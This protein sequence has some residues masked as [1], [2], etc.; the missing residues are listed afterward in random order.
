MALSTEQRRLLGIALGDDVAAAAI[1]DVIDAG[2]NPVAAAIAAIG[3]TSNISAAALSTSDTY[4]DAA[5][6]AELDS[7]M[8]E[9]E[10]RLD[11]IEAK[12]DAVIAGLKAAGIMAS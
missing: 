6:N 3:A 2:G 11:V 4:T 8:G 12:I 9:V 10:G 7:L 5:V 1:A